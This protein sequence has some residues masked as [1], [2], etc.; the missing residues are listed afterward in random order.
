MAPRRMPRRSPVRSRRSPRRSA[1]PAKQHRH[2]QVVAYHGGESDCL[3]D[4][5]PGGCREPADEHEKRKKLLPLKHRQREHE[6]VRIDAAV[7]KV[8]QPAERDRQHE[9][10][11]RQ[12]VQGEEPDRLVQVHL[13]GVLDH[14]DLELPRQEHDGEH[15]Q[16]G[17][18]DPARV[19]T[20]DPLQGGEHR[21]QVVVGR[22][23][24]KHV[25]EAVIEAPCHPGADGEEGDQFDQ[26]LEGDRR[27]HALVVL[28]GIEMPR[29]ERDGER[30][31]RERHPQRRVLEHGH[32]F[33]MRRHDHRRILQHQREAV[34]H[35]LQL[36]RDVGNDADHGDH[37]H[38]A[39]E[40][41]ALAVARGDEVGERGDAVLLAD[42]KDL[43]HHDP[44]QRDH[45]RRADVDGQES[46]AVLRGAPYAAVEGPR[47]GIHRERPM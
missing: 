11:D 38:H 21:P 34:R 29:A 28:G 24:R 18:P 26:R 5:H 30:G 3:Y 4:H 19:A 20:R 9:H 27:H 42:A 46:N 25:A 44:P 37:G 47:G 33:H 35:R 8:Q 23:A 6:S 7:R 17:E 1:A 45:Q 12:H 41:R 10:V 14:R 39:A 36:E 32:G 43:A 22:S 40:Q 13:V 15:R 31:E 16:D 2:D